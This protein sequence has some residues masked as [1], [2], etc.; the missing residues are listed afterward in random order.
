MQV[1]VATDAK[2]IVSW[3]GTGNHSSLTSGDAGKIFYQ[4]GNVV[5]ASRTIAL[6][7]SNNAMIGKSILFKCR[8]SATNTVTL[9]RNGS[10]EIDGAAQN[11]VL[12]S[13]GSSVELYYV[14]ADKWI[15]V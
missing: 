5:G 9:V 3:D 12:E 11:V 2:T 10:Q 7:A 13:D 4:T 14:A 1:G 8:A 15:I 6:P